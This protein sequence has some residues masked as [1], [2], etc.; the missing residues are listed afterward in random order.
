MTMMSMKECALQEEHRSL[1]AGRMSHSHIERE[2]TLVQALVDNQS[3]VM[4]AWFVLMLV[5]LG[6][7]LLLI[8]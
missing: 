7:F 5:N 4:K 8:H 2:T 6:L 3:P 1:L